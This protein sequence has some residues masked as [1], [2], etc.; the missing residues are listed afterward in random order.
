MSKLFYKH[1]KELINIKPIKLVKK[2]NKKLVTSSIFIPEKP[3]V[4]DKYFSYFTGLIK[5]IEVFSIRMPKDWIYRLYVDEL[6]IY[7]LDIKENNTYKNSLYNYLSSNT[8]TNVNTN[9]NT[10]ER[11]KANTT[12]YSKKGKSTK[13]KKRTQV[14]SAIRQNL[15]NLKKMQYLMFLFIQRI[16]ESG[17]DKY[18]NIEIISFRCDTATST[19]KYPGHSSTFGS[20]MRFFPLFDEDV[21]VFVS[22]NC[23]YP[24]NELTKRILLEFDSLEN[25]KILAIEYKTPSSTLS[26]HSFISQSM[27]KTLY[28][29]FKEIKT[30]KKPLTDYQELY[31]EC[32]DDI[33][34]MKQTIQGEDLE[35]NFDGLELYDEIEKEDSYM[36]GLDPVITYED[37]KGIISDRTYDIHNSLAAGLFGM[38]KNSLFNL[39]IELFAKFL[40]YLIISGNSFNFGIDE[41][42]LKTVLSPEI[43]SMGLIRDTEDLDKSYITFYGAEP[44]SID[45][46]YRL[47]SYEIDITNSNIPIN[48]ENIV[49]KDKT[50]LFDETQKPLV[51]VQ[52]L[53]ENKEKLSDIKIIIHNFVDLSDILFFESKSLL[54]NTKNK[55]I[56]KDETI[57]KLFS[58]NGNNYEHLIFDF[59]Y[60]FSCFDEFKKLFIYDSKISSTFGELNMLSRFP[61]S[62]KYFIF[63]DLDKYSIEDMLKLLD[64][65]ITHFKDLSEPRLSEVIFLHDMENSNNNS[66]YKVNSQGKYIYKTNFLEGGV[67]KKSKIK[68]TKKLNKISNKKLHSR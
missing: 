27:R 50:I 12:P 52:D 35:L 18:K 51:T 67:R 31:V 62:K 26:N 14:K 5:S 64:E 15:D 11:T 36:F 38:K 61:D 20:I 65:V 41:V 57:F 9:V 49:H 17:E 55:Q 60:L 53:G 58:K 54:V 56:S 21:D 22:V 10:N 32:I 63:K 4:S 48:V 24:I 7:S 59:K 29:P 3:S 43:V 2:K 25:K 34:E 45:Y 19:K 13:S 46:I 47:Y 39:R 66:K 16:K 30:S 6:F 33:L 42:I 37:R 68:K 8:S 28:K 1:L 44:K 40:K 23:R